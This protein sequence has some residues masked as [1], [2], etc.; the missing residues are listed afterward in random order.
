MFSLLALLALVAVVGFMLVVTRRVFAFCELGT[1]PSQFK[2][3][4]P[5]SF[6]GGATSSL[7]EWIFSIEEGI[8][9][10]SIPVGS[11]QVG[12]AVSYLSGGA[13]QWF[14]SLVDNDQ[15]PATWPDL[16]SALEDAYSSKYEEETSRLALLR[17]RQ[18]S[19]LEDYIRRFSQLSLLAR[20][21]DEHT[22]CLLFIEGLKESLRREVM[23]E[24]PSSLGEAVRCS[25]TAEHFTGIP[26]S[27]SSSEVSAIRKSFCP[28]A[29]SKEV[30]PGQMSELRQWL[31]KERRCFVC[32]R[33]GHQ[34]RDCRQSKSPNVVH[35]RN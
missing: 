12:Y 32:W 22:R 28:S 13:K 31:Q 16:R 3:K 21:L 4:S 33:Q 24:H 11:A 15:R 25:R 6:D 2:M 14:I 35:Q 17:L 10:L 8:S 9:H 5:E 1:R 7:R 27:T 29:W 23:R 20:S 30:S 26:S 34:A 18:D 19:S